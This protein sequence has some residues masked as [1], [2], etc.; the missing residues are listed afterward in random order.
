[1]LDFWAQ[2]WPQF[3]ANFLGGAIIVGLAVWFE[4]VLDERRDRRHRDH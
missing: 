3:W 4:A 1:M 2:F